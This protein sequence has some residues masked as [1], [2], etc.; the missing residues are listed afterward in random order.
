MCLAT[1]HTMDIQNILEGTKFE[2]IEQYHI[3][4]HKSLTRVIS[5]LKKNNLETN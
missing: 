1:P 4:M 5:V 3:R 2:I